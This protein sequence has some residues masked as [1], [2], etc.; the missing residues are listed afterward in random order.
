MK[1]YPYHEVSSIDALPEPAAGTNIIV[2][3]AFQ[4][5][6]FNEVPWYA[7]E[8]LFIDC[9]FFGCT[10]LPG[11]YRRMESCLALPRM[12][13]IYKA[14]NTCLYNG[15]TLY[16]GF[17][18]EHEETFDTCFDNRVYTEY[19]EKG[20]RSNDVRVTLG[21]AL[22][23][24]S[25]SDVMHDFLDR[26]DEQDIVGIM[27]G[28]SLKRTD[29]IF[30]QIAYISKQLT[31]RGKLMVSGGGPGA[32]EA[33]HLGA[34]MA[35]RPDES[36]DEALALLTP[37]PCFRDSGW[38]RT[39]F[40]VRKRFPQKR[41]HSLGVPTWLYGHEP[42]TPFATKIAKFF[43]NSI[44]EDLILA[45]AKG[46]ILYTPGSAGTLQEIFQEAAQNHYETFGYASPMVFLGTDFFTR[47]VPVYPLL[48]DLLA[49]GHYKNLLLTLTDDSSVI[50]DTLMFWQTA[51]ANESN[52]W[53]K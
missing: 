17:D 22:H 16:A 23:D 53:S 11:M 8:N 35:G 48:Q 9:C 24:H 27:G 39:A 26:Y 13:T 30:R 4:Y 10:L 41:Y 18:P 51:S 19:L 52:T 15:D 42:S 47:E 3:Y 5:I 33:T 40:E 43:Q 12:D 25:I 49:R 20:N 28:H 38:L 31:E 46:G 7:E 14:F 50:I 45:I 36:L 37:F 1:S 32:M 44:R 34:W 29:P 21:R 6:D 2:H